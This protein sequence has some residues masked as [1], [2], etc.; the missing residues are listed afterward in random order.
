[1]TWNHKHISSLAE[2]QNKCCFPGKCGIKNEIG[3][4]KSIK[5]TIFISTV[6]YVNIV[7]NKIF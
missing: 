2:R 4:S 1:M 6:Q 7:Q 5:M 3:K